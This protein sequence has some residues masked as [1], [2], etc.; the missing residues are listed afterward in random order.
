MVILTLG[1]Q[2]LA[3]KLLWISLVW[4]VL[5][6]RGCWLIRIRLASVC[7]MPCFL[8]LSLFESSIF[9]ATH[10]TSMSSFAAVVS[11]LWGL[12]YLLWRSLA[13]YFLSH[14]G[15]PL[16]CDYINY[17]VNHT[18][19]VCWCSTG[20]YTILL[21]IP[22]VLGSRYISYWYDNMGLCGPQQDV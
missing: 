11:G 5:R 10:C 9:I 19:S 2:S 4:L 20:F 22:T 12:C 17:R 8:C 21:L 18:T 13:W 15:L 14:N 1:W 6:A 16:H 7:H 3:F